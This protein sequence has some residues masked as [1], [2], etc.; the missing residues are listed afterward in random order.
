MSEEKEIS[1]EKQ[2][3]KYTIV[4]NKLYEV[5]IWDT[6]V[7][8]IDKENENRLYVFATGNIKLES[9]TK[10]AEN[11]LFIHT[12]ETTKKANIHEY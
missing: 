3:E 2:T 9:M 8:V 4:K 10:N 1:I 6:F 12:K 11:Y 7:C 5:W